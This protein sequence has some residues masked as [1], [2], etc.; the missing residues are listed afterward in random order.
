MFMNTPLTTRELVWSSYYVAMMCLN[1]AV[2]SELLGLTWNMLHVSTNCISPL[3]SETKP[4]SSCPPETEWVL[5]RV[6]SY[7]VGAVCL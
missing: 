3:G 4:F 7:S 5:I 2:T 1:P 6:S